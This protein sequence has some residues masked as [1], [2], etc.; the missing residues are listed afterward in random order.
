[1]FDDQYLITQV[2]YNLLVMVPLDRSSKDLSN[3]YMVGGV[4]PTV[5]K[6]RRNFTKNSKT[7]KDRF[8]V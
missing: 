2:R 5:P 4:R 1:M 8:T 7:Y 6:S 3:E